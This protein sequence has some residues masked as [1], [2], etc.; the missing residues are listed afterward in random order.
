VK[1]QETIVYRC[2]VCDS[3]NI[4]KNGTNRCGNPQYWCKDCGARR[5][6]NPK[7]K[8][9]VEK[10][11][12][13]RSSLLPAQATDILE[14]DELWSFVGNK[15]QKRWLWIALNRRTRQVVAFVIGDRSAQ[16]CRK[17]W[18]RIPDDYRRC[19]SYSDF[20][21]AYEQLLTTGKHHLVGKESGQTAHVE[22]W[23][24]TLRQ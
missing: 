8:Y 10:K 18:Q 7:H 1:I 22:R 21:H 20:W 6:L 4:V 12:F 9:P 24:C 14:L 16:T 5:V 11:T 13:F 15:K 19:H 23:N 17:L 2:R 3:E